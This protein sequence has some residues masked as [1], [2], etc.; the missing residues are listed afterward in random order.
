MANVSQ[1][2]KNLCAEMKDAL[3][4]QVRFVAEPVFTK[5]GHGH[6]KSERVSTLKNQSRR[7]PPFCGQS[8]MKKA[9]AQGLSLRNHCGRQHWTVSGKE[10]APQTIFRRIQNGARQSQNL[11]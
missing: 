5:T 11:S 8:Q 4:I 3:R 9:V 1:I 7:P 10:G 2:Q 6:L